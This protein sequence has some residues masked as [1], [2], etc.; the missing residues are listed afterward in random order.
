MTDK[1]LGFPVI[2][3]E[4][5]P[6]DRLVLLPVG[7]TWICPLTPPCRACQERELREATSEGR[8]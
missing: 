6:P 8:P 5:V 7:A 3:C 2:A 1:I 4:G